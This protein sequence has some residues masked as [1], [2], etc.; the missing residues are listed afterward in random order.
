MQMNK[1]PKNT[2]VDRRTILRSVGAAAVAGVLAGCSGGDGGDGSSGSESGSD[3]GSD[4]G[5]GSSGSGSGSDGGGVPSEV[6]EY[7]SDAMNYDGTVADETG[8][9]NVEVAVGAGDSG[10]A[11]G[12][13][14]VRIDTG[15]D[16][17]WSWTGAGGAHN[18]VAQDGEF[19]SGGTV[20][21]EGN[22][23]QHTFEDAGVY[24]YYCTP[25]EASGMKG[26][27]IVE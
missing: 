26:A 6:E 15:T 13:A 7:L 12:P 22:N 5:D 25:H 2:D 27:V 1:I 14:A 21:Q 16:I 8:S 11:F 17:N 19:D 20:N 9:G 23:F 10:L 18:V 3:G 4:G 24:L